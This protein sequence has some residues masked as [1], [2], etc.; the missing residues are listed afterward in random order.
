ME[1]IRD[2]VVIAVLNNCIDKSGES[3]LVAELARL[4]RFEDFLQCWINLIL[5]IEVVVAEIF[6]IFSKVAKE[7]N[8]LVACF[9]SDF[10]L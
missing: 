8:I 3:P 10:D 6:N 4:D 5:A 1:V 2:K 7:E 9:P